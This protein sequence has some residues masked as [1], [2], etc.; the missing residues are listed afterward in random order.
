M[1]FL[2][3]IFLLIL[4][5]PGHA[6]AASPDIQ[7]V[8]ATQLMTSRSWLSRA[9]ATRTISPLQQVNCSAS[10]RSRSLERLVVIVLSWT[11]G[12]RRPVCRASNKP[13]FFINR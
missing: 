1:Q 7:T 12:I 13:H 5:L 2:V 6:L 4:A 10:E 3:L 8:V 9:K 11:R